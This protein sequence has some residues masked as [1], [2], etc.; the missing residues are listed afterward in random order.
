[1]LHSIPLPNLNRSYHFSIHSSLST[2]WVQDPQGH[3]VADTPYIKWLIDPTHILL[4]T[5]NHLQFTC[6][7]QYNVNVM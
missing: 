5:F 4:C 3:T 7:T 6:N 1:M 2:H